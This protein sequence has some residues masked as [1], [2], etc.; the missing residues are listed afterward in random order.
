MSWPLEERV[1]VVIGDC[2]ANSLTGRRAGHGYRVCPDPAPEQRGQEQ[3]LPRRSPRFQRAGALPP[4]SHSQRRAPRPFAAKGARDVGP[5]AQGAAD[6][7]EHHPAH[8]QGAG[9]RYVP[10]EAVGDAHDHRRLLHRQ[11]L[12]VA[13]PIQPRHALVDVARAKGSGDQVLPGGGDE[14]IAEVQQRSPLA[15]PSPTTAAGCTRARPSASAA[16]SSTPRRWPE[17]SA[18]RESGPRR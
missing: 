11:G 9:G 7:V 14:P 6:R 4:F 12:H 3:P 18:L 10:M 17:P 16:P 15:M 8:Q 13:W 5:P 2:K 1:T